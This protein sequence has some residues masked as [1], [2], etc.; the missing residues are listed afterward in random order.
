MFRRR[1]PPKILAERIS[2]TVAQRAPPP[3]APRAQ[4]AARQSLFRN[5]ALVIGNARLPVVIKDLSDEGARIE[6]FQRMILPEQVW[7]VEATLR[8]K[9]LARVVWQHNG[10]AGLCFLGQ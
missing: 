3:E 1:A 8:L 4:R 7:L 9:R 6:F 2:K 10:V 5:A